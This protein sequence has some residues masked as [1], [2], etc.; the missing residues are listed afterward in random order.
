VNTKKDMKEKKTE[1]PT[2]KRPTDS[3]KK[4]GKKYLGPRSNKNSYTHPE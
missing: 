2:N 4:Q 3:T 1:E